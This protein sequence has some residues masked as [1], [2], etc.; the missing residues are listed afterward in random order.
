MSMRSTI[1]RIGLGCAALGVALALAGCGGSGPG[2]DAVS[3]KTLQLASEN[4][5]NA[6]SARFRLDVTDESGRSVVQASGVSAADEKNGQVTM[7]LP[8]GGSTEMRIV[9]GTAYLDV[10][11]LPL[12]S[13][14]PSGKRWVALDLSELDGSLPLGAGGMT[15]PTDAL[16]VLKGLSGDVQNVGDDTVAG[17]PATHYRAT[18]DLSKVAAV[19]PGSSVGGSVPVDVWI[20]G[21]DRVVKLQTTLGTSGHDDTLTME[22]VEFGV[23]VDVQAPPAGDVANLSDLLPG[24][25]FGTGTGHFI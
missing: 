18:I 17:Q 11:N 16:G 2:T 14:N 19:L 22:I 8:S 1:G 6:Q 7:Q 21:S 25:L 23:P 9:D 20:D 3:I 13:L 5:Q 10:S 15:T 4:T 12:G 24:G